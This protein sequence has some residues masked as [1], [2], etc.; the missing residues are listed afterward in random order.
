MSG[1]SARTPPPPYT[2]DNAEELKRCF[3]TLLNDQQ[4]ILGLFKSVAGHLETTPQ[5]GEHHILTEEWNTLRQVS[6]RLDNA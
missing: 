6:S 5:L 4:E 1:S 3:S 2:N